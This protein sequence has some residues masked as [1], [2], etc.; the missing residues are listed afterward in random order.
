MPS[1]LI[2]LFFF[3][4]ANQETVVEIVSFLKRTV[5]KSKP[6][7]IRHP[8]ASSTSALNQS[9]FPGLSTSDTERSRT[10]LTAD[11]NRLSVMMMRLDTS[12]GVKSARKVATATMSCARVQASIGKLSLI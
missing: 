7:G 12:T 3:F 4:L 6:S 8:P 10:E 11:F 2:Y 1:S 5:P 9:M